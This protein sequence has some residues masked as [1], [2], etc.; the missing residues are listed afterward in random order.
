MRGRLGRQAQHEREDRNGGPAFPGVRSLGSGYQVPDP[1]PGMTL[2][3]YFAGQALTDVEG[4][5]KKANT[6]EKVNMGWMMPR[7]SG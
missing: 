5:H 3:D 2:R 4:V 1:M 6:D 7:P